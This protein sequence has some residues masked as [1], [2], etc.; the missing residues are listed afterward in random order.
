MDEIETKRLYLRLFKPDDLED[1]FLIRSDPN[2]MRYMGDGKPLSREQV[3]ENLARII[4]HYRDRHFG[5]WAVIY[6]HN[7]QLTGYCGLQFFKQ[8]PETTPDSILLSYMFAKP[9]W[10]KGLATEGAKASLRYGFETLKLERIVAFADTENLASLRVMEKVGMKYEKQVASRYY[11]RNLTYYA[12]SRQ[13]YKPED[14]SYIL[15][16]VDF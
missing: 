15:R 5:L 3:S 10:G 2:V 1:L 7:S 14:C 11:N 6:K 13:A 8:P 12:I 4:Q 16:A 9:Y